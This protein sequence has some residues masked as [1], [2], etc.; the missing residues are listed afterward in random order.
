MTATTTA[1]SSFSHLFHSNYAA[2]DDEVPLIRNLISTSS[3]ALD[4]LNSLIERLQAALRKLEQER[5]SLQD[6]VSAHSGLLSPKRLPALPA[7]ILSAIF[8]HCLPDDRNTTCNHSEAPLLLGR[9]CKNWRDVSLSTPQLWASIH[10]VIPKLR[11][12]PSVLCP[13]IHPRINGIE[14]WLSRSGTLPLSISV[15]AALLNSQV[16]GQGQGHSESGLDHIRELLDILF[17][18][19]NRWRTIKLAFDNACMSI[20]EE[21]WP[22]G[23]HRELPCLQTFHLSRPDGPARGQP[24]QSAAKWFLH[25]PHLRRLSLR[26]LGIEDLL[27]GHF[28]WSQLTQLGLEVPSSSY[29]PV[30][31]AIRV[32]SQCRNLYSLSMSYVESRTEDPALP[33]EAFT[34]TLPFLRNLS[35]K[36]AISLSDSYDVQNLFCYL[37]TPVLQCLRLDVDD[38]VDDRGIFGFLDLGFKLVLIGLGHAAGLIETRAYESV[39][40]V[41][42]T[43]TLG[44]TAQIVSHIVMRLLLFIFSSSSSVVSLHLSRKVLGDESQIA[45]MDATLEADVERFLG[46]E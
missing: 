24:E 10:I 27:E 23:A 1:H 33:T 45:A 20:L 37:D 8:T 40:L 14:A 28:P 30:S 17:Q 12:N 39:C 38:Y 6:Y 35:I 16:R 13:L 7:E 22:W 9:I 34:I 44:Y 32:L 3:D 42:H 26:H 43:T 36:S 2:S 25:A 21:Y 31:A 11:G 5:D 15:Y 4:R 18:R 19:S 46:G 41:Q 29:I